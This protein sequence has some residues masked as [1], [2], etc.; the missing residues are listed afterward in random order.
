MLVRA[1]RASPGGDARPKF[2]TAQL[3]CKRQSRMAAWP[4]VHSPGRSSAAAARSRIVWWS[5]NDRNVRKFGPANDVEIDLCYRV[6]RHFHG[7]P[8]VCSLV[9]FGDNHNGLVQRSGRDRKREER[10]IGWRFAYPPGWL[11]HSQSP[12]FNVSGR[13]GTTATAA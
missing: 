11:V 9:P 8:F 6:A 12:R 7:P 10:P 1:S 2:A 3:A 13:R 4:L 5:A